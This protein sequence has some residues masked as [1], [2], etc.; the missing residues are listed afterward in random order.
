MTKSDHM[1]RP[2][3]P[4]RKKFPSF[5]PTAEHLMRGDGPQK[6][7]EPASAALEN[8]L[9]HP[10]SVLADSVHA[11]FSAGSIDLKTGGLP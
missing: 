3:G 11:R 4:A 5:R 10:N 9:V 1:S 8:G 6:R 7:I 2:V